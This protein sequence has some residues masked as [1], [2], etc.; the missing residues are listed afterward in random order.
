M[1]EHLSFIGIRLRAQRQ[2]RRLT[3]RDLARATG[4]SAGLLSKIENFRSIPSLPVLLS[5][6]RELRMDPADLFSG[7]PAEESRPWVLVRAG[8]GSPVERESCHGMTYRLLLESGT[9]ASE[10]Q[11]MCV[12]V[13]PGAKRKAVSGSGMELIYMLAGELAYHVGDDVVPLRRGDTLFFDGALPH[14]PE[15]LT[16][17]DAVALVFYLLSEEKS[18]PK[19]RK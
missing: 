7:L 10:F 12:S 4:L 14:V 5:I 18:A 16:G 9:V 15:N 1:Y 3:L 6:A 2:Q 19:R 8:E 17:G 11:L 13:A